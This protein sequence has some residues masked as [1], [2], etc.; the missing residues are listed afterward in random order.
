MVNCT[1]IRKLGNWKFFV[2]NKFWTTSLIPQSVLRSSSVAFSSTRGQKSSIPQ[3]LY[4]ECLHHGKNTFCRC[5][6]IVSLKNQ[7]ETPP[8]SSPVSS[9]LG[10]RSW[11]DMQSWASDRAGPRGAERTAW[12]N[13]SVHGSRS[14]VAS[15]GSL[16]LFLLSRSITSPCLIFFISKMRAVLPV[17]SEIPFILGVLA[18]GTLVNFEEKKAPGSSLPCLVEDSVLEALPES[19]LGCC[20]ESHWLGDLGQVI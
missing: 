16:A 1:L 2:Y 18:V 10:W 12:S 20:L 6:S 9:F 4:P 13:D 7:E 17:F 3:K 8:W 11:G 5:L 19:G 14:Q 15:P